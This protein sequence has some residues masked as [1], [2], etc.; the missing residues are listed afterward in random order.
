MK[1]CLLLIIL[2]SSIVFS[3]ENIKNKVETNS[4]GLDSAKCLLFQIGN[5]FNLVSFNGTSI[6]FKKHKSK[7]KAIR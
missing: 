5:N 6:S 2:F 7:D 1:K 3:E 4:V